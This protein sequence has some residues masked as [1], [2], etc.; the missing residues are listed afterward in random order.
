MITAACSTSYQHL[1]LLGTH[2]K[3]KY[4]TTNPSH[5][6]RLSSIS[7]LLHKPSCLLQQGSTKLTFNTTNMH[8]SQL[9]ST[10]ARSSTSPQ[11][12]RLL[13][14][15]ALLAALCAAC[16]LMPCWLRAWP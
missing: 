14:W 7:T 11:V 15:L 1:G 5:K 3:C 13:Q 8:A 2:Y 4:A 9:A 10:A 12:R 16:G 6:T